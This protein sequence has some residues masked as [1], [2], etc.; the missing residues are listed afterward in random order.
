[1]NK[2]IITFFIS[3][4]IFGQAI[5]QNVQLSHGIQ[6]SLFF[7]GKLKFLA[8]YNS[9]INYGLGIHDDYDMVPF[10]DLKIS[11]CKGHLGS[12]VITRNFE[13]DGN[14]NLSIGSYLGY[15]SIENDEKTFLPIFSPSML[16]SFNGSHNYILGFHSTYIMQFN[17]HKPPLYQR[18]GGAFVSTPYAY[19]NYYNDGGPLLK[20]LGDKKDRYWTGGM[21]IGGII[22]DKDRHIEIVEINFEKY[23]GYAKEAFEISDYLFIDNVIPKDPQFQETTRNKGKFGFKYFKTKQN[24]GLSLNLW[25]RKDDFQ[26]FIHERITNNPY[27]RQIEKP[28]IDIEI[29]KAFT[30]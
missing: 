19:L 23:T 4:F 3:V 29:L 13:I 5:G 26:D 8:S 9:N 10:A 11:I 24:F 12:N 6:F 7:G 27:H 1:M 30:K 17:T 14:F 28:Y 2:Y 25:N 20:Y 21:S 16:H 22:R 15:E 18:V